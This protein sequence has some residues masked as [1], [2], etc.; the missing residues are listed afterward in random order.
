MHDTFYLDNGNLLRTHTSPVQ[1]R[2]IE[3]RGAPLKI[4]CPGKVYR[5]DA[6]QNSYADVSPDRR[7]SY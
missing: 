6:D 3:K 1:I 2:S 5:S 7:S 4:I